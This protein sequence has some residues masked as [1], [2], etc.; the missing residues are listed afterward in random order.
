MSLNAEAIVTAG[1]DLLDSYGLG[2]LSMRRVADN[3]GVK[4][5]ALYYHI[6]N[7]QSLLAAISDEILTAMED[8]PP[9]L[10]TGP[11]L[12]RWAL[13]LREALLSR[14]DGAELVSST[15]ALGLGEVDPRSSGTRILKRLGVGEPAA[16]MSA[17]LHFVL[18]HVTGEQ[19]RSQ[20]MALGVVAEFDADASDADF[21]HGLAIFV[22]GVLL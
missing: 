18:G 10:E 9:D 15:V 11:W 14:R 16:T 17:L 7:K 2:D 13:N 1:L 20:L 12:T 4:A 19:T 21:R 6:P 3:L 5:G 22:R 8:P